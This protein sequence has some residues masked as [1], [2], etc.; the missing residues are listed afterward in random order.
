MLLSMLLDSMNPIKML[1]FHLVRMSSMENSIKMKKKISKMRKKKK[2]S[3]LPNK[4]PSLFKA[5]LNNPSLKPK[6][7]K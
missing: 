2:K 7:L 6:K 1:I 4:L 3:Q 5:K